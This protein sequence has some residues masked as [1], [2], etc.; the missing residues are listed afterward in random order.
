MPRSADANSIRSPCRHR[1]RSAIRIDPR[2]STNGPWRPGRAL[3]MNPGNNR[4]QFQMGINL[5][6]MGRLA[7]AIR[8]L[9]TAARQVTGH[10]SRMEAYLGYV[11]ATAGRARDARGVLKELKD[12]RQDQYRVVVRHRL[13][14]RRPGRKSAGTGCFPARIRGPSR[15]IRIAQPV[16][17]VQSDRRG[18]GVPGRN[19]QGRTLTRLAI[20]VWLVALSVRT[21]DAQQ[22]QGM[23]A[24]RGRNRPARLY[25]PSPSRPRPTLES[26]SRPRPLPTG[27]TCWP[28]SSSDSTGSPSKSPDSGG[29]SVTS[30]RFTRTPARG[31]TFS[32]NWEPSPIRLR[33]EVRLRSSRPTDPLC[34]TPSA[35]RRSISCR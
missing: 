7:D 26:S 22:D 4:A 17:S 3:E 23:I 5:V 16:R 35:L 33:F 6:A 30:S 2:A 27:I 9:E 13:D 25:P 32:S 18:T 14:S 11:Y 28:R 8:E 1:L 31:W 10:N 29:R 15:R 20:G 24:G 34:R 21:P 19:P 12:H